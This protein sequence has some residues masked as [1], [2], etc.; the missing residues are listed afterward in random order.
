MKN[1]IMKKNQKEVRM[2]MMNKMN[3]DQTH[4]LIKLN[5]L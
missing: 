5:R 1:I 4:N 3:Q 2:Q